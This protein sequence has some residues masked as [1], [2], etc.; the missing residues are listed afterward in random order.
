MKMNRLP[1]AV[2]TQVE[3]GDPFTLRATCDTKAVAVLITEYYGEMGASATATLAKPPAIPDA[4]WKA[5]LSEREAEMG[6]A[7]LTEERQTLLNEALEV[8]DD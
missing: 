5:E 2:Y 1:F 3:R 6:Y 4:E 7:L 8:R